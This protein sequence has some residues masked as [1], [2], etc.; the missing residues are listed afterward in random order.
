[1]KL[2]HIV[3][4]AFLATLPAIANAASTRVAVEGSTVSVY[5]TNNDE[6]SISCSGV[7][8]ITYQQFGENGNTKMNVNG[9]VPGKAR[10][11]V[12]SRFATPWAASTLEASGDIDCS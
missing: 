2:P 5:V 1:M 7:V 3:T 9:S 8:D 4:A 6:N 12:V 10:N 11:F